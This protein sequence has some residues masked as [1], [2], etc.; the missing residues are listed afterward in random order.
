MCVGLLSTNIVCM[1]II[2]LQ[3]M[4]LNLVQLRRREQNDQNL[5]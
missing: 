2:K 3:L 4:C 5:Y 1:A